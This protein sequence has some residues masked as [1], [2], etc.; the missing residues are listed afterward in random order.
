[1]ILCTFWMIPWSSWLFDG[2]AFEPPWTAFDDPVLGPPWIAF[3][4]PALEL[5]R[6][7]FDGPGFAAPW[8]TFGRFW[9]LT[10]Q[11]RFAGLSSKAGTTTGALIFA[12]VEFMSMCMPEGSDELVKGL[13]SRRFRREFGFLFV[14]CAV[15]AVLANTDKKLNDF[16]RKF[17]GFHC[18]SKQCNMQ[19]T[20]TQFPTLILYGSFR[21]CWGTRLIVRIIITVSLFEANFFE[22]T[23]GQLLSANKWKRRKT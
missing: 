6:T 15:P 8:I 12:L 7:A 18:A 19:Q 17:W 3:D 4:G 10:E 20:K 13:R 22:K 16:L 2:P 9:R 1:M 11:C 5:C 23:E 21:G 14:G